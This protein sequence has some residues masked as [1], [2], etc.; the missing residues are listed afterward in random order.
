[1]DDAK[2][3]ERLGCRKGV[4]GGQEGSSSC[5]GRGGT[6]IG[7]RPGQNSPNPE[8]RSSKGGGRLRGGRQEKNEIFEPSLPDTCLEK[9]RGRDASSGSIP[10]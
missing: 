10:A 6:E 9:T 3:S 1:M 7:A 4:G 5:L 2:K 8:G